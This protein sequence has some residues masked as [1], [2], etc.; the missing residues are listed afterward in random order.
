M[1]RNVVTLRP[2]LVTLPT[3]RNRETRKRVERFVVERYRASIYDEG[4]KIHF[5]KRKGRRAAKDE[6]T[7]AL[8]AT[9]ANW[10]R[11]FVLYPKESALREKGE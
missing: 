9:D 11:V 8:D 6:V 10:R 4:I 7:R 1:P 5:P 3:R 2:R